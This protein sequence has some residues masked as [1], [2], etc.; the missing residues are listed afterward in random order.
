MKCA[1]EN[2]L[3]TTVNFFVTHLKILLTSIWLFQLYTVSWFNNKN[4]E[5][6]LWTNYIFMF[7]TLLVASRSH[8][9]LKIFTTTMRENLEEKKEQQP[10]KK[11]RQPARMFRGCRKQTSKQTK[12]NQ[13]KNKQKPNLF[14]RLNCFPT[15]T[16]SNSQKILVSWSERGF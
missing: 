8:K 6:K 11:G 12:T 7:L 2:P 15:V 1:L 14:L 3:L 9:I 4:A 10:S 5:R 13:A 16:I